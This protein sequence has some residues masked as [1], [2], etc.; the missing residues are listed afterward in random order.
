MT[1][2]GPTPRVAIIGLGNPL[3]GDDGVG[4]AVVDALET[5]VP[6]EV[7]LDREAVGGLTLMER[8]VGREWA[9]LVDAIR[10]GGPPG[11]V[12]TLTLDDLDPA[13]GTHLDNAHDATLR[14]AMAAGRAM[15]AELPER[16][17]IVAVEAERVEEF[18][19]GL[20]G[21]V[22]AAVDVAAEAVLDLLRERPVAEPRRP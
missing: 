8:L 21:P 4:W 19:D 7:E 14:L 12:R 20:S 9:V 3:L 13:A 17:D 2:R 22:A 16:V 5:R 6:P 15:G 11:E 1:E 18:R 10:T